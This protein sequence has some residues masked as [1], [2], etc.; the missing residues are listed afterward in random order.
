M[1]KNKMI[2]LLSLFSLLILLVSNPL[3]SYAQEAAL[4]ETEIKFSGEDSIESSRFYNRAILQILNKT[5]A[6]TAVIEAKIGEIVEYG[7][8]S[9]IARKCWQAPLDQKPDSKILLEIFETKNDNNSQIIKNR[10]FYGWM[11]ASSP[12][13]SS[14][15]HPIYD[16]IALNCKN[17]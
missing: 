6:K 3:K 17:R 11:I 10:I 1:K 8:I 13:I 15:E 12:S 5:T 14:L 7:K 4:A 9:I 16:I 2:K